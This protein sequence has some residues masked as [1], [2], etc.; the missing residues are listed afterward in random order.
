MRKKRYLL[1]ILL[2]LSS[3]ILITSL[4]RH[5]WLREKDAVLAVLPVINADMQLGAAHFTQTED[6]IKK[7]D[8]VAD[9]VQ[10]FKGDERVRLTGLKV[11]YYSRQNEP[12]VI[13]SKEGRFD[14]ESGEIE[15]SGDVVVKSADGDTLATDFLKY[16]P[17]HELVTTDETFILKNSSATM[18]GK[19][20]VMDIKNNRV[21]I[22]SDVDVT[23][24]RTE[25]E[26]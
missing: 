12:V 4:I 26:H 24:Y 19:G 14:S 6:G 21:V 11:S 23:F 13:E 5:T 25:I 2:S 22:N 8:L 1:Y 16:S 10:Y 20:F 17:D 15:V 18:K 7:W 3:L 9:D